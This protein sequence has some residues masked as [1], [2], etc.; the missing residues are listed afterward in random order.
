[1]TEGKMR[2]NALG[3]TAG[4]YANVIGIGVH[5]Y[6]TIGNYYFQNFYDVPKYQESL[7][8]GLFPIFRGHRQSQDDLI[9]RD[10]IQTLRNFF[11]LNFR[12]IDDKY[13]ITFEEY[14]KAE[15][16][17]LDSY[18]KDELVV[19]GGGAIIITEKGHQFANTVCH[20]FDAYKGN[21]PKF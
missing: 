17:A 7:E 21:R 11:S 3:V 20:V 16:G 18:I 1:M 9:R 10:V 2:W 5:G 15:L 8:R 4:R 14:F 6:S 19:V 13:G 12:S